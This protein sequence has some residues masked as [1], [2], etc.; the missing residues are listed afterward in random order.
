MKKNYIA[1]DLKLQDM[2][3]EALMDINSIPQGDLG[4]EI[5]NGGDATPGQG[6]DSRY[7]DMWDDAEEE[8]L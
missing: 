4:H 5:E 7:N 1:P 2:E 6:S 8:F 3:L